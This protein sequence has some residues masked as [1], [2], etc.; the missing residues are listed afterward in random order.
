[1]SKAKLKVKVKL[2]KDFPDYKITGESGG[3]WTY[4][5]RENDTIRQA[6][7]IEAKLFDLIYELLEE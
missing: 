2:S 4:G 6:T 7:D 3:R 5:V 1:M